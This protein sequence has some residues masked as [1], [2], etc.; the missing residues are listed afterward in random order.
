MRKILIVDD[1]EESRYLLEVLL[2]GNGYEVRT[3]SNGEEAPEVLKQE[4]IHLVISDILM[5]VMDGFE[6]CRRMRG[7][8]A[9]RDIPFVVY[10]ATYTG[11][12]DE[13]FALKI[14]ADRF[15][16]KPCEPEVLLPILEEAMSKPQ[17][18]GTVSTK[19]EEKEA[20]QVY[21][22]RLVRKLEQKA[23]ELEEE[24]R[25]RKEAEERA[26][27]SADHWRATFDAILDPTALFGIDGTVREC[28]RA[29]S[30]FLG[31]GSD[32]LI[33]ERCYRLIHKTEDYMKGCP[34]LL[35]L[36]SGLQETLE[37]SVDHK[38]FLVV[39]DPVKD[40]DGKITG[41]VHVMRDVTELKKKEEAL[42][43]SEERYRNLV[44]GSFDGIF[45]QKGPKIIYVNQRLC[46]ML[47][48]DRSEMIGMDHWLVYH[49]D[50]QGLTRARAEARMRGEAVPERYEVKLQRKD[51]SFFHGE[52]SARRIVIGEEPGVQV[53]VKDITER[54][55]S[56][57]RIRSSEERY[58][59]LVESIADGILLLDPARRVISCNRA[60]SH[61][62][63]YELGEMEGKS[64]RIIH[65]S[66]ESYHAFG[67]IAY[68]IVK[69]KGFFRGEWNFVRKDGS[70]IPMEVALSPIQGHDGSIKGYVSV[71]RDI[72]ERKRAERDMALLQEQLRQSQKMEAIGRLAGGIAHDFN[73]ILTV[74]KG[75]CQLSLLDLREDDPL[76][77]NLKEIDQSVERA[78]DLTRQ[79]LAFGRKQI[80]DMR[81]LDL[82]GVVKG[83]EKMM[84]RIIGEDIQL[85]T[86]LTEN[87]GR[88][89]ADIGQIE[90]VIVNL[91][92]NARDAMPQGGTLTIETA[93]VDLDEEYAKR[94]VGVNPGPYVMLS[95]SDTGVG[96]TPEVK[97]RIFEPFF[98]TKE[99]GK[100]T[101]LGLSTV[102][103]IVKQS[104][105]NIWVYSEPGQGTTFKIY[106][107]RVD[108]PPPEERREE[109]TREIPV[110]GETVL[111]VE[112]EEAVRKLAVRF[113]KKLGYRV[114][115]ASD[116]GEALL[117]CE[118]HPDP[119]HLILS[120]VVLPGINGREVV[121]RLQKIHPEARALFMSGY[122]DNV[123]VH[124]GILEGGVEFLQKPFT[125]EKL[126]RKVRE[127]LDKGGR[128]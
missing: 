96:M 83:L 128:G 12:E 75:V 66:D 32:E 57:E 42:R 9:L 114:L 86:Y 111:V 52:I 123:I 78:A 76:Y 37:M 10:T 38:T 120:D 14:G 11:P 103:G 126:A 56:D 87:V 63:G 73:N 109:V 88:V 116:G 70:E 43:E 72:T 121:E 93:N 71:L 65:A 55:R 25:K 35:S 110:G 13:A 31:R 108:E 50:D 30:D 98:T 64:I 40:P 45:I 68:P 24:V 48:Y 7:E 61:L 23:R 105:G 89:K 41:F 60:F 46:E 94:H 15:I 5:P 49:P 8:E 26:K 101:G 91:V 127:V 34:L 106:L 6:L 58:R 125:L 47:G 124:F 82:N 2:K 119:I 79:L 113:L 122:T 36:R 51:G 4:E 117:L 107:P 39:V 92:V 104:G 19:D 3:A 20:Y 17:S 115:E 112:D 67:K 54:K 97:E 99:R 53:W 1:K 27:A 80:M 90:Q 95:I 21:S 18:R 29:F 85:L 44:E 22:E 74:M 62:F 84:K 77:G 69:E 59:T 100:G 28:N 81:V 33:G 16:Q 102:Y 118:K